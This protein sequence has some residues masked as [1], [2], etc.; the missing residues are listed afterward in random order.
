MEEI[1]KIISMFSL[2]FEEFQTVYDWK[3]KLGRTSDV[4]S[5]TFDKFYA[6]IK[7]RKELLLD[8]K[9]DLTDE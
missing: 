1:E 9:L 3:M 6:L 7:D 4:N 5:S 2:K 8:V